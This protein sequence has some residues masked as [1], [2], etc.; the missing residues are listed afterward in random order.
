MREHHFSP[1]NSERRIAACPLTPCCVRVLAFAEEPAAL[2][3]L[4]FPSNLTPTSFSHCR[5]AAPTMASAGERR[6]VRAGARRHIGHRQLWSTAACNAA[7][8]QR[9]RCCI[10]AAGRPGCNPGCAGGCQASAA[11]RRRGSQ[12][13][14]GQPSPPQI[15]D[16]RQTETGEQPVGNALLRS[17]CFVPSQSR[18][19]LDVQH[20]VHHVPYMR[21]HISTAQP[22]LS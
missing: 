15:V 7:G 4:F 12:P 20:D 21:S 5:R 8:G 6:H 3:L 16:A 17:V 18:V 19:A 1:P 13:G 14:G 2:N 10:C 22:L 11:A 9:P